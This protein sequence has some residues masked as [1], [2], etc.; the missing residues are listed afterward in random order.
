MSEFTGSARSAQR[1]RIGPAITI[2][3][4]AFVVG[5][6]LMAYAMRRT[7]GFFARGTT[8]PSTPAAA[9][10]PQP[11]MP[12]GPDT[13]TLA[14]RESALA[15]Q[16]S[17]LEARA[18]RTDADSAAAADSAGKAEAILVA[19]AARR[20]LERGV[21]LGYLE[22]ELRE[23]FSSALPREVNAV[24]RTARAPVT[25]EDLREGLA[26]ATPTLLSTQ[27]DWWAGVGSELR[28]LIVV[29][30]AGTPSPLPSD[31]LA[32]ARRQLEM[33]NVEAALAEVQRLPG[34]AQAGNW[35]AA[36]GRW[37]DSRR[38]LDMLEAAAITGVLTPRQDPV[39]TQ[40]PE[41]AR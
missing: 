20:A 25:L 36:A 3:I 32:R 28:N 34:A 30:R 2:A 14:L 39:A 18:A 10:S 31:R 6:A 21:G 40:E 23:R 7:P 29:H 35:T 11:V 8:T 27:S 38:A 22:A 15:A 17:N 9:P 1:S 24:I 26:A 4:L 12:S 19:F 5:L 37:I 41:P 16:L 33:G 13:A